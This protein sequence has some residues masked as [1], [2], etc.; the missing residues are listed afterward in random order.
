MELLKCLQ[1]STYLQCESFVGK[2]L[3]T[4]AFSVKSLN[5]K[6][7]PMNCSSNIRFE[8]IVLRIVYNIAITSEQEQ[9]L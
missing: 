2:Y 1:V 8:K 4:Y 5:L 7:M 9:Y 3:P 6:T